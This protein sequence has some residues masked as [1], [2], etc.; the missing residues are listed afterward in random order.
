MQA[1]RQ[2]ILTTVPLSYA[3]LTSAIET[4]LDYLAR[5]QRPSGEFETWTSP[6]LDFSDATAYLKSIY[7]T[8]FVMH[9]LTL[10]SSTPQIE[11]MQNRA[12][13]FLMAEQEDN[14]AWNYEGRGNHR[15]PCDQDDTS[16]AIAALAQLGIQPEL[17]FYAL[18]WQNESAPGGP[19]YTWIGIN[20]LNDDPRARQIDGLVNANILFCAG[21]L[22]LSLPGTIYY[23]EQVIQ[24]EAYDSESLYTPTS[25][26]LMYALS[27]AYADGNVSKLDKAMSIMQDYVLTKLPPPH[28][29]TSAFKLACLAVSLLNMKVPSILIR[30]YLVPLLSMQ[31][32]DGSWPVDITYHGFSP[33]YDGSPALSTALAIEALAKYSLA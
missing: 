14:G 31:Q 4:G 7:T 18:L 26:F 11:Q 28:A 22:N 30:P 16:C 15:L 29:E 6:H 2:S 32:P 5:V 24:A 17:S 20:D 33:N 8:T 21:L 23:L 10:L 9:T 25:H 19:Y 1:S 13:D 12:A 3:N 27:R